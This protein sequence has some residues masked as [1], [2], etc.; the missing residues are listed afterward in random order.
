MVQDESLKNSFIDMSPAKRERLGIL[1]QDDDFDYIKRNM[2][3]SVLT[4]TDHDK[5][6]ELFKH[7]EE[8]DEVDSEKEV[9]D[10]VD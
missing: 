1:L 7:D 3:R 8:I 2:S 4:R 9:S 10:Y 6:N 5:G